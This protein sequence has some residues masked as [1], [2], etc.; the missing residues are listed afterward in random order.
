MSQYYVG[1]ILLLI[2][3][4]LDATFLLILVLN[5]IAICLDDGSF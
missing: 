1:Y 3:M 2:E 4:S 5:Q